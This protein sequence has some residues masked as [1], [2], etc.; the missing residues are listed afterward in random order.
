MGVIK[1]W[2][3]CA[4]LSVVV[5]GCSLFQEKKLPTTQF[6]YDEFEV[7]GR[8]AAKMG[9]EGSSARIKWSHRADLDAVDVYAPTGSIIA[10]ILVSPRAGAVLETK[11]KIYE[12]AS[13]EELTKQV[14]GW[15]L[16][17]NGLKYWARGQVSPVVAV[18]HLAPRDDQQRLTYLEQGGWKITFEQYTAG[19]MLPRVMM[20]EFED[21]KIRL[22]LDKWER[23]D[24]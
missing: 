5:T 11:D 17:L 23:L 22:I 21:I 19:S 15:S 4:V 20:L 16:P 7:S 1:A 6:V 12:A 2:A 14:L 13:V 10:V 3:F 18:D 8:I 24:L 9:K